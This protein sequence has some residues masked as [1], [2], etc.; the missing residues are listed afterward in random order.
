[1][2]KISEDP[3]APATRQ[4]RDL[5]RSPHLTV[6]GDARTLTTGGTGLIG[7]EVIKDPSLLEEPG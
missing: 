7:E 4:A 5:Y 2:D 1:M 6:Y 3:I